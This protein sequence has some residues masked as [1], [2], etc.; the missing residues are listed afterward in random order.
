MW[1]SM[2]AVETKR[3]GAIVDEA[4]KRAN[5]GELRGILKVSHE[6]TFRG[7]KWPGVMSEGTRRERTRNQLN[8]FARDG[9]GR[10]VDR[11]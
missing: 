2:L 5:W 4:K 1:D 11:L 7:K 8:V 10:V 3:H 9:V 6:A